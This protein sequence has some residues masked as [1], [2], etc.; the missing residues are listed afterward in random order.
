MS[1]AS[2]TDYELAVER[3][4]GFAQQF[5]RTHL[6]LAC[7]AAF[8]LVLTPDLLYQIWL[9]FVP[10]APWTAVAR[11]LLSRLCREVGYELYEMD[12]AVR[13]LLL[14]EL[15]E[16]ERFGQKQL[17]KLANFLTNYVRRQFDGKDSNARDL[18]Q[19]QYWTALAYTKPNQLSSELAKA[20]ESRLKQK[21]WKELFRLASLVE[22]FAEPLAE[23]SPPLITY[24]RG[25]ESFTRGDIEGATEQFSKLPRR[26]RLV[27]IEGV[28]LSIPEEVPL[29]TVDLDFLLGLLQVISDSNGNPQIVYP[30]LQENLDKLDD[31]FA[32]LLRSCVANFVPLEELEQARAIVANIVTLSNLLTQFPLGNRADNLDIAITGYEIASS[33]FTRDNFPEQWA[34]IQNYIAVAY[35]ERIKGDKADNLETAI[36]C[37]HAALEIY[38]LVTYPEQWAMTQNNLGRAYNQR[39]RGE[40]AENLE[41]ALAC[42][43]SALQVQTRE[44]FPTQWAMVQKNLGIT[45]SQ[46]IRGEKAENV[47]MA[48]HCFFMALAIYTLQ[49]FPKYW[50]DIHNNLA[51]A[52]TERI[53]GDRAE[54]LEQAIGCLENALQV[55]T[56]EAFPIKWAET[57]SNLAVAYRQRIRGEQAE[58]LELAI[59][60]CQKALQV[61]TRDAFPMAWAQT[62]NNLG[63][64]Y[65]DRIPGERADNLEQTISCFL[66]ALQIYT[67]EAFP[68]QWAETQNNLGNAYR[69]RIRGERTKN[70]EQAIN[71]FMNALQVY[72]LTSFPQQW[73]ETQKNLGITYLER[74]GGDQ[75]ENLERAIYSFQ[76]ALQIYTHVSFPQNNL[77]TLFNLACAYQNTHRFTSAY[78]AFVRVI[79]ILESFQGRTFYRWEIKGEKQEFTE[80]SNKVYQR[81]VKVCL[82]LGYADKAI[83]YVERSKARSLVELLANYNLHPK[84]NIPNSILN[85]LQ[86]LRLE[87]SIEQLRLETKDKNRLIDDETTVADSRLLGD[88]LLVPQKWTRLTQ[89]Q[90]QLDE[91]INRE[92]LPIDAEFNLT[93]RIEAMT[94]AQIKSIIPN[95]R[96]VILEWYLQD[97]MFQAFIL[98]KQFDF[99]LIVQSSI[100]EYSQLMNLSNEYFQDYIENRQQWKKQLS[101][102]I[103][104]LAL[105][106]NLDRILSYIPA[107]CKQLILIPH[108]FLHSLPLHAIPLA[109]S[110]CLLDRFSG[111]V[112]YVPSCQLLQILQNRKR[113]DFNNF[114]A[115]QNPNNDLSF[116]DI[117]VETI[118]QYFTNANILEGD[119]VKKEAVKDRI[120][121]F[122]GHGLHF[123]GRSNF[124]F[125]SPLDSALLLSN[126]E[127][128]TLGE[129]FDLDLSQ[130]RLVTLSACETGLIDTKSISDEYIGFPGA[131]LFAGSTSVVGSLW[132]PNDLSTALLMIKFYQNLQSAST[133]AVALNQA[134]LWLRHITKIQ[135]Q[136]WIENTPL[137]LDA[138][139]RMSLRRRF[140][141]LLD[142]AQP[143][144]EPFH[145]AAFCAIGQ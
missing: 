94:F 55:Y 4:V 140:Y 77:E 108:R 80:L 69:D 98:T 103:Q 142:D 107:S 31:S 44:A 141:K 123:A 32:A 116:A 128:L 88:N 42:F 129:I 34:S 66:A 79:D 119:A 21:N 70:L 115:I 36:A 132:A 81:M 20:I 130:S 64:A 74:R 22:T 125:E 91:L 29:T 39:I 83:E 60:C 56:R 102:R 109:D 101:Q 85:E 105:I 124:N 137:R 72:T 136:Q 121:H 26:E 17:E 40:K 65:R 126:N 25:M 139:V 45:Y 18:A 11:V 47:E 143:F 117:E 118:E 114:F 51:V 50:A 97:D 76:K 48:I 62:Q 35:I 120:L 59:Y 67:Q 27:D 1:E 71:C 144:R 68:Q 99:P 37:S 96:T 82:Q 95:E 3:V 93:Q 54:N 28:S 24:A 10:Q 127:S 13:N 43:Q 14:T 90:Q 9:R 7:H 12:V 112:R 135:L 16:D 111:G 6:D 52:Y 84:G 33:I 15:K 133:V 58:N 2:A 104:Y 49:D 73:A 41:M 92:I 57:Q 131:F 63:N 113:P 19:A 122:S 145:W 8:P 78:D 23:F 61:Y 87:I 106:L 46:R 38:S 134:Q 89:L 30:I 110:S 5:D 75:A 86:R 138:T 100:E 53:K